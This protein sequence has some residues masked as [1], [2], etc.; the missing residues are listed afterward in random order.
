MS[1]LQRRPDPFDFERILS[2]VWI[3]QPL[4]E[5]LDPLP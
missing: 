4:V 2:I 5:P 3:P 1:I